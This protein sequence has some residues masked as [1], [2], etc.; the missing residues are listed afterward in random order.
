[1]AAPV[2]LRALV[3]VMDKA[4]A[5]LRSI[6]RG[7]DGMALRA[8][9]AQAS[10]NR[11]ARQTGLTQLLTSLRGAGS[12]AL[13]LARGMSAVVAQGLAMAGIAG[14]GGIGLLLATHAGAGDEI[15][16]LAARI[17]VA[18]ESYQELSYAAKKADVDQEVFAKSLQRVATGAAAAAGG[19][20]ANLAALYGKLGIKLR[21]AN[22]HL[23]TSDQLLPEIADGFAR[24]KD[25][26]LRASMAQAIFGDKGLAMLD[27]L[28]DGSDALK[29]AAAEA[30]KFGLVLSEEQLRGLSAFDGA[31]KNLRLSL[32]GLGNA[33]TAKLA[34]AF[35]PLLNMMADFIAQN[36]DIIAARL[37]DAITAISSALKNFDWKGWGQTLRQIGDVIATVV[38][39]TGGWKVAAMALVVFINA[40]LLV[41]VIDLGTELFLASKYLAKFA[42]NMTLAAGAAMVNFIT[43]LQAGYTI[44]QSLS[45]AFAANPLGVLVIGIGLAIAAGVL[46]WRNWDTI[47]AK[48]GGVIDWIAKRLE[49]LRP[50]IRA[51]A[52][53]FNFSGAPNFAMPK[54]AG[55]VR[56]GGVR[57]MEVADRR[58]S[59]SAARDAARLRDREAMRAQRSDTNVTVE[60]KNKP[61]DVRTRVQSSGPAKTQ[62]MT[63]RGME[64][65]P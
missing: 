10:L 19:K 45:L 7:F 49:W 35:V 26:T 4:T 21:D 40:E 24:N 37:Q 59:F 18:S 13:Q 15:L 12:A 8:R 20:N 32:Q 3:A 46:L 36:R 52:E 47:R 61:D 53:A 54:T 29:D 30:R 25:A 6:G 2:N 63:G 16:R 62:V 42:A 27:M 65:A 5:P 34:P 33:L 38:S 56:T 1:M 50:I 11:L 22:G 60:F 57:P 31:T 28:A 43:G 23:R 64:R 55:G 48:V 39:W 58:R 41:S 51:V 44:F 14:L 9:M 17:G